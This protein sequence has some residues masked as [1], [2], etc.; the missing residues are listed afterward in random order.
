[1]TLGT[2]LLLALLPGG[3]I[4]GVVRAQGSGTPVAAAVV[5]I[6]ELRRS[7]QTDEQGFF[8]FPDLPAGA[9]HVRASAID[10]Q[11]EEVVAE[12]PGAGVLRL[13]FELTRRPVALRPV[14][15]RAD[16]PGRA[17]G[18][19]A[20]GPPPATLP[21]RDLRAVPALAEPDVFRAL[22]T[23]PSVAA[24]S[25]F[26]SALYVRGGSPD[27]NLVMLDGVPLENPYHLGGLFGAVDPDAVESVELLPGGF[28]AGVGDRLSSVVDIRTREGGRDRV[29]TTGALSL[30][31]SRAGVDGP[32]PGRGSY[33]L[34]LRH[35]YLDLFTGATRAVGL[36]RSAFPYGFTDAHLK[37][38]EPLPRMGRLT[39][40]G[41][42]DQEHLVTPRSD[43]EN[44]RFD[45][46]WGSRALGVHW[47]QPWSATVAGDVR[48]AYTRFA[49]RFDRSVL[50][51]ESTGEG[52]GDGLVPS[53]SVGTRTE[54]VLLGAGLTW[55]RR[56]HE[57]HAGAQLDAYRFSHAIDPRGDP[58]LADYLPSF[59]LHESPATLAAYAEDEWRA[60]ERLRLR[61][62]LRVL[63]AGERGT[64]WLPRLG[65]SW[66]ASPGLSLSLAAGRSAQ[67]VHSLRDGE[68]VVGN[69][70]AYDL[71]APVPAEIGL[72]T[73]DEVIAGAEWAGRYTRVRVETYEKRMHGLPLL[74]PP[75][76]PLVGGLSAPQNFRAGSGRARGLEV[77]A[78]W[79]RGGAALSL[80][81]AWTGV[82]RSLD[83]L[84]YSPRFERPHTLDL[85]GSLPWG[86]GGQ[87]SA[88]LTLASGQPYSPVVGFLPDYHYDPAQGTFVEDPSVIP[89]YGPYNSARLP[90][91]FRLDV[92]LRREL[93]PR[94]F[95]HRG[96]V[97]PYLQILN[98]LNTHNVLLTDV[99][100]HFPPR[101][102]YAPQLPFLP[103]LGVEWSF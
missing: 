40:S 102:S 28:P 45:F 51:L 7:V 82:Q 11:P 17:S 25:D 38:T 60:G 73:A 1:M 52:T 97:T 93:H 26:S 36:T 50:P 90:A 46:G 5:R 85:S 14:E 44:E 16:E 76:N 27:Q 35:T 86:R 55:Y 12:V 75:E 10:Y 77:L 91:Y 88:R 3:T 68:S 49:G 57:L 34:S 22:Q 33:A 99:A 6:A 9:W 42:V 92:G 81:Y 21:G 20:A 61:A 96:A 59:T 19:A 13:E 94:W 79:A 71:L 39:V 65:A 2:L 54:S 53:L 66:A 4:Q 31:S 43:A 103:T 8:V 72:S 56:N 41:Y 62:G 70:L 89:I 101:Q 80:A 67:V 29:R 100:E 87:A 23:L 74:P 18:P 47:W 30:I 15:A 98:V 37:V 58:D 63:S 64:A 69:V 95:G 84:R 32:L 83:T 48:V 24:A 78:H